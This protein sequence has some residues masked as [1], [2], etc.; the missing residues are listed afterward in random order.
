[1]L[2]SGNQVDFSTEDGYPAPIVDRNDAY[3]RA[4]DAFKEAGK[5]L[6]DSS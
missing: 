3:H 1:M 6:D 2:A 5:R 4:R